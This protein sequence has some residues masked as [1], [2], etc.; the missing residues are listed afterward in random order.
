ML[1][2]GPG[3]AAALNDDRVGQMLDRL[4]DADRATL[5]TSTVLG[6]ICDFGVSTTQLHNDSTTVTVTGNYPHADGRQ[7]GGKA[8]PK[9][10]RSLKGTTRTCVPTSSS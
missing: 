9:I 1:G 4:C 3:D 5:I 2:L 6:V 8:T 10:T 7:R